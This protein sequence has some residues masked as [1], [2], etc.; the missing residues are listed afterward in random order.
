MVGSHNN[1]HNTLSYTYNESTITVYDSYYNDST[2][3]VFS[4]MLYPESDVH[5][6]TSG[7]APLI[8]TDAIDTQGGEAA[9][10]DNTYHNQNITVELNQDNPS[11]S[12][13]LERTKTVAGDDEDHQ[14]VYY[15]EYYFKELSSS[16][17]GYYV[18]FTDSNGNTF[19]T[20]TSRLTESKTLTATNRPIPPFAVE[21]EWHDIEDPDNYPEVRFTLYQGLVGNDGKI[22]EGSIFVGSNGEK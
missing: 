2:K 5:I 17:D 20:A 21:K 12:L 22:Q 9:S 4:D 6:T 7:N 19:G 3:T 14:N 10:P 11:E 18:T 13:H 1:G 16:P 15:Y 8:S